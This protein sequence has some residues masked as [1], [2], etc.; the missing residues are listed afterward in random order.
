[1]KEI[2]QGT[3]MRRAIASFLAAAECF[4][5]VAVGVP[6]SYAQET[7]PYQLVEQVETYGDRETLGSNSDTAET[8]PETVTRAAAAR[9]G[10]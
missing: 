1:M 7:D 6:A 10:A 2:A 9:L 3:A 4:S 8:S 5:V